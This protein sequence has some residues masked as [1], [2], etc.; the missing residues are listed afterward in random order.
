MLQR[1]FSNV[2]LLELGSSARGP[3]A[4][5]RL[6]LASARLYTHVYTRRMVGLRSDLLPKGPPLRPLCPRASPVFQPVWIASG[7]ASGII[8]DYPGL[9]FLFLVQVIPGN[10]T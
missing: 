7:M 9:F 2:A 4:L 3:R 6:A 10:P 5:V 1:T 8:R